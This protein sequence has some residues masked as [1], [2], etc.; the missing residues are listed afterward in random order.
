VT[1]TSAATQHLRIFALR[2][3]PGQDLRPALVAFTQQNNIHA[4]FILS[5]VGS[6]NQAA[7]RFANQSNPTTIPGKLEII[8]LTGTLSPD[9]P[10]LHL[11]VAD[12]TGKTTAGHLLDN[13]PIY[14]T[15]EIILADAP[16]LAFTR[17][18]DPQ[19]G[20]K[21]LHIKTLSPLT[22]R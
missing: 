13:S 4:G 12:P 16:N 7:L 5:A 17:Q 3:T 10:H 19:T 21:E 20:Y 18:L 9:G 6:L 14:T 2:L 8:S 1:Q 15:A 22:P 11:A